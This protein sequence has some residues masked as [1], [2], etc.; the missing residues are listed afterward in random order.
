MEGSECEGDGGMEGGQD[1][2]PWRGVSVRG[3]E[4][5]RVDKTVVHGGE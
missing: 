3:M 4:G 2:G 1:S 5:W